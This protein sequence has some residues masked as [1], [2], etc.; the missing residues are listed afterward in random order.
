MSTK[1]QAII[2]A[3]VA[4]SVFSKT[5]AYPTEGAPE[6]FEFAAKLDALATAINAAFPHFN[7]NIAAKADAAGWKL[8]HN[9]HEP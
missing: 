3:A 1:E 7:H 9:R 4:V 8:L 2:D 5:H 6:W